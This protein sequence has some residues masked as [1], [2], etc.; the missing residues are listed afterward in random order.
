MVSVKEEP[1]EYPHYE[2]YGWQHWPTHPW[3]SLQFRRGLGETQ[4]GG[5]AI[6]ECLLVASRV[7]PDDPE[8]WFR[9]FRIRADRNR[10]QG[11]RAEQAGHLVTARD[12]WLRATNYYRLS[13]FWLAADDPRRSETL[14]KI[15]SSFQLAGRLFTNPVEPVEIPYVDGSALYGYF[16]RSANKAITRSPV[17]VAC[18]GLN[19]FKE[20]LYFMM[21]IGALRRGIS[22]LLID[23]PGQ[24]ATLRRAG[25][26]GRPDFEVPLGKC[27][28]YLETRDDVDTGRIAMCGTSLGGYYAARA[29]CFEPRLAAAISHGAIWSFKSVWEGREEA[30]IKSGLAMYVNWM[31]GASDL[32]EATKLA[33]PFTLDEVILQNLRIPYLVLH[34]SHDVIS[35]RDATL[36]Y[37]SARN[38]GVDVT[39]R[40]VDP[41]DTGA[42]HCQHDNPTVGQ[43]IAFD[44]LADRFGIS[45]LDVLR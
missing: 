24:G 28:D 10:E 32:D 33:E 12:A 41:E 1:V 34:G 2:P 38:A 19:S 9:E 36:V 25:I 45:Q 26:L 14:D 23:G 29:A 35:T 22:C 43:E 5:G 37:D 39:L 18:G 13:E 7:D 30:A 21:G 44:W 42:E 8:T 4:Y 16:L 3:L 11:A 17:V 31:L 27:I 15:E 40:L 20:E 6:S